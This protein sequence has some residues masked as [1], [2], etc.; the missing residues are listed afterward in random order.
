MYILKTLEHIIKLFLRKDSQNQ[1]SIIG[2]Y[3]ESFFKTKA[4]KNRISLL[5]LLVILTSHVILL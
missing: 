1:Q 5:F 4:Q 2:K 3:K